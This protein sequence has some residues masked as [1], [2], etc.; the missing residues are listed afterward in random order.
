MDE[1][2]NMQSEALAQLVKELG[3]DSLPEEKQN[4]LLAK[5]TEVLIKRIFVETMEKLSEQERV[6]YAQLTENGESDP[7]LIGK[8]LKDHINDYDGMVERIIAGFKEEMMRTNN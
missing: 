8:F 7:E 5:M 6:E 1:N 3:I 2:A 4:E